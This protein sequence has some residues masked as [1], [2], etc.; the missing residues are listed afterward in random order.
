MSVG[1]TVA[2]GRVGY[3]SWWVESVKSGQL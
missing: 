3:I 2:M 1:Q